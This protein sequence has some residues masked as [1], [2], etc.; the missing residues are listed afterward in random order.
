MKI[1]NSYPVVFQYVNTDDGDFR[2]NTQENEH[3]ESF[4]HCEWKIV[5]A[6]IDISEEDFYEILDYVRKNEYD[7]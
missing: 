5:N 2:V 3:I 7:E 1:L 4:E 6:G